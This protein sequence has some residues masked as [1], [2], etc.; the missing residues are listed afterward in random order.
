MR[1]EGENGGAKWTLLDV[2]ALLLQNDLRGSST[3]TLW[4][5]IVARRTS[6]RQVHRLP[7]LLPPFPRHHHA[8]G[9]TW[10][11]SSRTSYKSS[12]TGRRLLCCL[13]A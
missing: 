3:E 8:N 12:L 9:R 7:L 2:P 4:L 11:L 5:V 13:R 10:L 6:D 1:A